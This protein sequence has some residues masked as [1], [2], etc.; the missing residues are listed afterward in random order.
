MAGRDLGRLNAVGFVSVV[1]AVVAATLGAQWGIVGVI[2]GVAVGWLS[3]IMAT[4]VLAAPHIRLRR[5]A[6]APPGGNES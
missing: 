1:V 2:Y 6:E 3:R 5:A 4:L